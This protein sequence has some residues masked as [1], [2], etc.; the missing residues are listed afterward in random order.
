MVPRVDRLHP[1]GDC[2]KALQDAFRRHL[3]LIDPFRCEGASPSFVAGNEIPL[4]I[5]IAAMVC[6]TPDCKTVLR[7]TLGLH[8][9][10]EPNVWSDDRGA[11]VRCPKCQRRIPWPPPGLEVDG[12]LA[13]E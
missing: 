2:P 4:E 3:P 12:S 10:G 6:P 1:F 11:F 9:F 8:Q 13:A 7:E 5:M